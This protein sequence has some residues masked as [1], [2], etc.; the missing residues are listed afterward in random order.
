MGRENLLS[1][2][3]LKD[4]DSDRDSK[5]HF[6]VSSGE[7][8]KMLKRRYELPILIHKEDDQFIAECPLFYV[9]GN[10]FTIDAAIEDVKNALET[11]LNDED[12]I[13]DLPEEISYTKE[14]MIQK[15]LEL[16]R[17]YADPGEEPPEYIQ[18]LEICVQFTR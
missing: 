7:T 6:A 17:D 4:K 16:F 9:A 11:Y 5:N 3:T 10:G 12:V 2:E 15:S 14:E 1:N 8:K 13:K 18:Y